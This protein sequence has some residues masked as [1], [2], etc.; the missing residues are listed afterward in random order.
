MFYQLYIDRIYCFLFFI[1]DVIIKEK[2]KRRYYCLSN[3]NVDF[4][5]IGEELK[6]K[7]EVWSLTKGASMRPMLREHRDIV[8]I[9][10]L[11]GEIRVGDVVAYP[12][13]N[14][15]YTLHRIVRIKNGALIIRGD[16]NYFTEYNIKKEDIVGI[17][18]EIY[19]E[20]KYINCKTNKGYKLYTK[21]IILSYPF[22]I[23]YNRCL[24]PILSKI[25]HFIFK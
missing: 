22:R 1:N 10:R 14:N 20:G 11:N 12:G 6:T 2:T 13:A 16:N 25:K 21:Y 19:R 24:R 15:T 4:N 18:K 9:E 17:L 8:V 3:Q 23:F 5:S 7:P